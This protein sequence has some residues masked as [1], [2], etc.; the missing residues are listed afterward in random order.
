VNFRISPC[1][2]TLKWLAN[3][4][5]TWLHKNAII[6]VIATFIGVQTD[7]KTIII[8]SGEDKEKFETICLCGNHFSI[9]TT[10]IEPILRVWNDTERREKFLQSL[11]ENTRQEPLPH[12][13]FQSL[14]EFTN[15]ITQQAPLFLVPS[16]AEEWLSLD[17]DVVPQ[18]EELTEQEVSTLNKKRKK[19]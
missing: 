6:P 5:I 18:T 19:K 1:L 12:K 10:K 9:N 4:V 16:I 3:I 14:Y 13:K 8:Q 17:P 11:L 2:F 15:S 7:H